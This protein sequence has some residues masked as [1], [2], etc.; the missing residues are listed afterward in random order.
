M[1]HRY[2]LLMVKRDRLDQIAKNRGGSLQQVWNDQDPSERKPNASIIRQNWQ[3]FTSNSDVSLYTS[4][5]Y[6]RADVKQQTNRH[7]NY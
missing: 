4:A 7:E 3:P 5:K 2:P 1:S 6:F